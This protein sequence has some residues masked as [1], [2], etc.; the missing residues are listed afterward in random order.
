M[1]WQ[2]FHDEVLQRHVAVASPLRASF[3]Y[4]GQSRADWS[5]KPSFARLCEILGYD[6]AKATEVEKLLQQRF[7]DRAH[8]YLEQRSLPPGAGSMLQAASL[9]DWWTLMQHHRAP[10]RLLDWTHSPLVALYFAANEDW[11]M[12]GA[13]WCVHRPSIFA[14]SNVKFGEPPKEASSDEPKY[15]WV[16]SP[17]SRVLAFDRTHPTERMVAQQGTFTISQDLLLDHAV[18]L[19]DVMPEEDIDERPP[20]LLR[21]KYTIPLSAKAELMRNLRH[22]NVTAV[23]LFPGIDGF[24][25]EMDE[26]VRLG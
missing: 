1:S 16:D 11:E 22:M 14:R 3:I 24:G 15:W 10:T 20:R 4:R 6:R 25:R 21:R 7:K 9:A 19:A 12:D 8:L 13:L 2:Q 17:T 18:G 5:L 23:A 26:I